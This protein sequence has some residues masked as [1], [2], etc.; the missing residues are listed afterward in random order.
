VRRRRVGRTTAVRGV[1]ALALAAVPTAAAAAAPPKQWDERVLAYVDFVEGQRRLEFKHP[2]K[3]R[4]LPDKQFEKA[5]ASGDA[6]LTEEE[7]AL[8]EQFAGEL[9]ALGLADE[10]VDLTDAGEALDAFGTVG[11]YDT[12]T[13]E[14][15]VRGTDTDD[16]DVKLTIV[17]ELVHALQDQH[18]DIDGLY[19]QTTSGSESLGID[20]LTEGDATAVENA[21]LDTLSP[22]QQDAYYEGVEEF[23][24]E[25]IPE[26]VP[27]ALDVFGYAPYLLG[28]AYVFALDPDGG[29]KGLERA[30]EH[31][32]RSEEVLLDP[33]ALRKREAP[34]KVPAPK[35]L[36]GE[37]KAYDPEEFGVLTL[38]L[39][40]ATRLDP[41]T[42]LEAVTGWG[43][44]RY[45][46]FD[47]G[48]A[49]CVRV[50]VTGDTDADTDELES[51]FTAWGQAMPPGAVEVT[52]ADDLVMFTACETEGVT[53]PSVEVFDRAF[54]NV[55]GG[56][57][58]TV[59]DAE[60]NGLPLGQALC[61]GDFVSTDAEVVAIFDVVIA[62][63]REPT[64]E[65]YTSVDE[66]YERAF[67]AC[68][69]AG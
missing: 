49:A 37:R 47:R 14:L 69:V 45:V 42:A 1:S 44:D 24:E 55:L 61:V 51:A 8:E 7:R 21:Y 33:V 28:E 60:A 65:E 39:M 57:V 54:Y 3:V 67:D 2:V 40:L 46:G 19:E 64:D 62:E 4:F 43:G 53:E 9:V 58:Y 66:S 13:E 31:P 5:F 27:Y 50:N 6:E 26:D 41:R 10:K 16:V 12:E 30:Y 29:T 15:V 20:F 38:Y 59:L 36:D 63:G 34:Q 48:G 56:R 52:R 17:H 23:S 11:Y 18:Y 25:P 68:G 35:L 22:K 32:P